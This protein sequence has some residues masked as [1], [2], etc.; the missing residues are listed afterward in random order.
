MLE[1]DQSRRRLEFDL[2]LS[3]ITET[4]RALLENSGKVA[5]F[6]LLALGWLATSESAR[7][8]L[9]TT[10]RLAAIGAL[11]VF[12]GWLFS[13]IASWVGYRA[14]NAALSR[15]R[16]LDFL[17]PPAYESR[18]IGPATLCAC[19]FGNAALAGLLMAAL[20][21]LGTGG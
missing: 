20:L 5:A 2:H 7:S 4:H 16:E 11:A 9:A 19:I 13:A 10:P 1:S 21:T 3:H 18:R 15:L 6:L 14:S 8:Y 17:S 12:A